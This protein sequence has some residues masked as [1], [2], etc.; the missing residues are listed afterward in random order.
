MWTC[1]HSPKYKHY[2]QKH[3]CPT[4]CFT[5]LDVFSSLGEHISFHYQMPEASEQIFRWSGQKTL[6]NF[7]EPQIVVFQICFSQILKKF[8]TCF[9]KNDFLKIIE[10][11]APICSTITIK[12]IMYGQRKRR[13]NVIS[14][15]VP[16]INLILTLIYNINFIN[17]LT[18]NIRYR[19]I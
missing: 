18:F 5:F 6:W 8:W 12:G 3:F 1:F 7:L 17:I 11:H 15:S 13:D 14:T 16:E 10:G 19:T 9:P 2:N 4:C